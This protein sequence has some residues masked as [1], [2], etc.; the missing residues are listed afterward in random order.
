[1]ST[2]TETTPVRRTTGTAGFALAVLAVLALMAGASAPSPFYPVLQQELG[3]SAATMTGIF[4][5]YAVALLVTLL[6]AG[7]VSDHL[8]R[9]PVVSAGLIVLAVSML[10]FWH[11]DSVSM[12]FTAR[13]VQGVAAGLLM[14]SLSAMVVDLEPPHLAG[15]AATLNSV[16]PLAGLALGALASGL[17]MDHTSSALAWVFA[18]LTALFV[19]LAAVV[20]L[21]PETAPRQEGLLSSLKPRVGIPAVAL[22]AFLRS[23]PA[24]LAGWATG[25]LYLSLGA[26]LVAQELGRSLHVEQGLVVTV[27]TGSGAAACFVVRGWTSRRI[28]I[29]G[30]VALSV[31][32]ALTLAALAAGSYVGFVAA[33][34]VAGI[35]FGMSFLGIMRSI[36]PLAPPHERGEL[37][38]SVFVISYLA[39]GIPAVAAGIAAPHIG[40]AETTYVYGGT[41]VVLS[42]V[43]ALLRRFASND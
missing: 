5:V 8:G 25:G 28:T 24:L 22:P 39:F 38:A 40:L 9:R 17:L 4:A 36:T 31:G 42:A 26:P 33:G 13:V 29:I 30:T 15:L 18:S 7:S 32:T 16:S 20:W 11:A 35:G 12:L 21:V 2:T 3:F 43:A 19:L 6:F 10:A 23:A 37:F 1:M 14:S 41:V 34:L 27:L